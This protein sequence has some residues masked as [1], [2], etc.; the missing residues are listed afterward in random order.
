MLYI[1]FTLHDEIYLIAA[2]YIREMIPYVKCKALP[3]SPAYLAGL[4]NYRGDSLPVMDVSQLMY[5]ASSR[6]R[7]GTRIAIVDMDDGRH[8]RFVLGLLLENVTET[9]EID[10][11][12]FKRSGA[13]VPE[14]RYLGDIVTDR[15]VIMQ[16]VDLEY[17]LPEKAYHM[18]LEHDD[19]N[20]GKPGAG[21]VLHIDS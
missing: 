14:S 2:R 9:L 17:I 10:E 15:H 3:H 16:R 12:R 11:T 21:D 5:D 1:K 13:D 6:I 4:I 19:E 18:L 7:M 20:S 8:E